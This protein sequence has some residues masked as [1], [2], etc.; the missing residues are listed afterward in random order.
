MIPAVTTETIL[1]FC[2]PVTVTT[3]TIATVPVDNNPVTDDLVSNVLV[4]T[5]TPDKTTIIM[6]DLAISCSNYGSIF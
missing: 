4:I 6:T 3:I 2:P 5:F 1:L